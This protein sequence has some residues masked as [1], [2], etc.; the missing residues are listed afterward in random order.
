MTLHDQA[1][2]E[3]VPVSF[4]FDS[5]G[6]AHVNLKHGEKVVITNLPQ[7][8]TYTV[9]ETIDGTKYETFVNGTVTTQAGGTITDVSSVEH[10]RNQRITKKLTIPVYAKYTL[11]CKKAP[12]KGAFSGTPERIRV[13]FA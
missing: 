6:V 2:Q 13:M 9:Q 1:S 7:G 4:Q 11:K 10:F 5:N 3:S 8:V 12:S